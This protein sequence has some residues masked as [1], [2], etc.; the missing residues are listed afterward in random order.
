MEEKKRYSI[1]KISSIMGVSVQTLRFYEKIGLFTPCYTNPETGYRYYEYSQMH[2]IDRIRY[3]QTLG[4][5]LKDIKELYDGGDV[6]SM[7]Q[8]L[9]GQREKELETLRECRDRLDGLNWYIDYFTF[10][11]RRK[12][13]GVVYSKIIGPRYALVVEM[14]DVPFSI[15]NERFYRLR[16]QAPYRDLP[17]LRQYV[18]LLNLEALRQ[19]R[20]YTER[21]GQYLREDPG[22]RDGHVIELPAGEYLCFLAPIYREDLWTPEIFEPFIEKERSYLVVAD[23]Y[24][25]N[26]ESYDGCPYEIQLLEL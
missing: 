5:S 12:H 24:E 1:G 15:S 18:S 14:G 16:T 20:T 23:E 13:R 19:G 2:K 25:D 26:L 17:C 8:A 7:L 6:G 11:D 21:Y 3:L 9:N 10:L 22:F 4:L